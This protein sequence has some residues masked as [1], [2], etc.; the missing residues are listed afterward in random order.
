MIL[1][2]EAFVDKLKVDIF[3]GQQAADDLEQ[4]AIEEKEMNEHKYRDS[5]YG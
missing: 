1:V 2:V 5:F 3:N 4:K